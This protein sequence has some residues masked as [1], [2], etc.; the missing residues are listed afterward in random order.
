MIIS[1]IVGKSVKLTLK[2]SDKKELADDL[3]FLGK[4]IS[5]SH[6]GRFILRNLS[7]EFWWWDDDQI[8][9]GEP[10][11]R[12]LFEDLKYAV[13]LGGVSSATKK[14]LHILSTVLN[15]PYEWP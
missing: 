13:R 10:G 4:N 12:D 6:T 7:Q 1:D 9:L 14:L 5:L 2:P 15:E 11:V 3:S 8:E